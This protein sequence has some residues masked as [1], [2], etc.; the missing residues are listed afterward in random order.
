M[1]I[2]D[3]DIF[4]SAGRNE[5]DIVHQAVKRCGGADLLQ[6]VFDG[7]TFGK[8]DAMKRQVC[9]P[10]IR[11]RACQPGNAITIGDKA[12]ADGPAYT[13][14]STGDKYVHG[15]IFHSAWLVEMDSW[16]RFKGRQKY[17]SL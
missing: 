6:K 11:T 3:S 17:N 8:V 15:F 7:L 13:F 16:I 5:A 9:R 10:V 12:L 1:Q 2:V 14:A 4:Q